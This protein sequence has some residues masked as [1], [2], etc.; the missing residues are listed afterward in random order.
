MIIA[1]V[2]QKGGAGKTTTAVHL[3]YW[4]SLQ[5]SVIVVDADR[6]KSSATWVKY[7]N[8]PYRIVFDPALSNLEFFSGLARVWAFSGDFSA[9]FLDWNPCY[10]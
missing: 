5:K 9:T 7:L 2:N 1:L 8:I 6:Q 10:G 3:A 4:L